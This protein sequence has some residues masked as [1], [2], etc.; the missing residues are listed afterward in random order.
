MSKIKVGNSFGNFFQK[1]IQRAYQFVVDFRGLNG[2]AIDQFRLDFHTKGKHDIEITRTLQKSHVKNV[3]LPQYQF[4]SQGLDMGPYVKSF[5]ILQRVPLDLKI[6]MVEDEEHTIGFFI[7]Y[8]QNQVM[9]E[10]GVYRPIKSNKPKEKLQIAVTIFGYDG[11]E[12][13]TYTYYN[14]Y[15]QSASEATYDYTSNEAI[16]H[17]ISFKTDYYGVRYY[18]KPR[19]PQAG[20]TSFDS[21]T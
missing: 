3:V 18:P 11:E 20:R 2:G 10:Y 9:N 6:E 21:P 16:S 12:I 4:E 7:Q 8:L 1:D 17:N 15:I 19:N 14:C 13:A 5:P